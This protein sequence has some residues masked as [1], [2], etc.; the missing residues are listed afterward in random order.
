MPELLTRA[1]CRKD[2]KRIS[3]GSSTMSPRL[4]NRSWRLY[5]TKQ[6]WTEAEEPWETVVRKGKSREWWTDNSTVSSRK[7]SHWKFRWLFQ[8]KADRNTGVLP[9]IVIK[10]LFKWNV[11]AILQVSSICFLGKKERK[12]ERKKERSNAKEYR[13]YLWW[14]KSMKKKSEQL[15]LKRHA[16]LHAKVLQ[17]VQQFQ[18]P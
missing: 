13:N 5:W 17:A 3:A 6:N 16:W 8:R 1:S 11:Y 12:N 18:A 9:C 10:L 2:W 15:K 7:I 4:P 14:P